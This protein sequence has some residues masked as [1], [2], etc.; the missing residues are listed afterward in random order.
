MSDGDACG[1]RHV[2]GGTDGYEP[3]S[4]KAHDAIHILLYIPNPNMMNIR[5]DTKKKTMGRIHWS[6]SFSRDRRRLKY[7]LKKKRRPG[8]GFTK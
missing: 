1:S 6:A 4:Q 7:D 2:R 5:S 8:G 3:M